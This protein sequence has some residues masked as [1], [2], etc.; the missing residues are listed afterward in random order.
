M[1]TRLESSHLWFFFTRCVIQH[2]GLSEK[3]QGLRPVLEGSTSIICF[4]CF[5]RRLQSCQRTWFI[6]LHEL[7]LRLCTNPFGIFVSCRRVFQLL[8]SRYPCGG[9]V[10]FS[11]LFSVR[12]G[13]KALRG[14][15][16]RLRAMSLEVFSPTSIIVVPWRI[17]THGAVF[18][19]LWRDFLCSHISSYSVEEERIK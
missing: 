15:A 12:R 5:W 4:W 13:S 8:Q 10:G 7:A 6:F 1:S 3:Y 16:L 17:R 11:S 14:T 9:L 19:F 2:H 18:P